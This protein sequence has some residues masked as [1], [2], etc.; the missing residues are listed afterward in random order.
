MLANSWHVRVAAFLLALVLQGAT[1]SAASLEVGPRY[2][3]LSAIATMLMLGCDTMAH[4][5]PGQWKLGGVPVPVTFSMEEHWAMSA[6]LSHQALTARP[7]EPGLQATLDA[8]MQHQHLLISLRRAVTCEIQAL[9]LEWEPA[10]SEWLAN[11]HPQVRAVYT[12]KG[13]KV[14]TQV[15]LLLHLLDRCGYPGIFDLERELK[16]GFPMTGPLSSGVGWLPRTD[17]TYAHPL[18]MDKFAEL[19]TDHLRHRLRRNTPSAHWREMLLELLE[20]KAKGRLSGPYSAPETWGVQC[21]GV[22]G[23]QIEPLPTERAFAA[24]CFAVVQSDKVRRC[25]DYRRSFH[26]ATVY[27]Q[28]TP[29]HH[30]LGTHVDLIHHYHQRGVC[31]PMIWGQDLDAAYRQVPVSPDDTAY[32]VL[33][34]PQGHTLWRHAAAPFGATASVWAFNRFAD[35]LVALARRLL[36]VPICHFVDDFTSIDPPALADSSCDSFKQ[37]FGQMGLSMKPSKEQRPACH[38]K[39]LGV[40]ITIEPDEVVLAPCPNRREKVI[41]MLQSALTSN[42]MTAAMAQQCAGKL[43]F[44]ATTFF[45][46]VGKAALQP[47]Y[48]R[49]HGLGEAHHDRLTTGLRQSIQVLLHVLQH[50]PPRILPL[51]RRPMDKIAVIYTDA[52]FQPGESGQTKVVGTKAK[53]G[54]GFVIRTP[55]GTRYDHGTVPLDFVKLFTTRRAYIFMLEILAALIGVCTVCTELPRFLI[56]FI[57][58]MAGK[59][60]LAKG[61]GKC[62]AVNMLVTAFWLLM[63]DRKWCPQFVYVKSGLNISDPISRGDLSLAIRHGWTRKHAPLL[64]LLPLLQRSLT[65][66]QGDFIWLQ[67][68]LRQEFPS[69]TEQVGE[70]DV[71]A[72]LKESKIEINE[73]NTML[74]RPGN[75]ALILALRPSVFPTFS[76]AGQGQS[77]YVAM[78]KASKTM[79]VAAA[80][81]AAT[82]AA[83]P[84]FLSG[85]AAP[86][87]VA[88]QHSRAAASS[89]PSMGALNLSSLA[90]AGVAT[91]ALVVN[92]SKSKVQFLG[93]EVTLLV[94]D[95]KSMIYIQLNNGSFNPFAVEPQRIFHGHESWL[96]VLGGAQ[97]IAFAGLIETTGFFQAASTTDGRG[98]R[99]GQFSM[100][101]STETGEPGNYG[102]GFPTFLG[103]D[104]LTGSAWGDWSLYTAS[105][106][107]AGRESKVARNFFGGETSYSS[108]DPAKELGVQEPIGI[109]DKSLTATFRVR[110]DI[111]T[112]VLQ[113]SGQCGVFMKLHDNES[114][115]PE[116]DMQ[117]LP[118]G[119]TLE[120][121]RTLFNTLFKNLCSASL[122]RTLQENIGLLC[123]SLLTKT[124]KSMQIPITS[125]VLRTWEDG[126]FTEFQHIVVQ[127]G[128]IRFSSKNNGKCTSSYITMSD[129]VFS[130][131]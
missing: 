121:L 91:S 58:N 94:R 53:N 51:T 6:T 47:M 34:T 59:F 119:T 30:D 88:P 111:L 118:E 32:T 61:Y 7:L 35:A 46:N 129:T 62:P 76:R 125:K 120:N 10:T 36:M 87:R 67:S 109:N 66:H 24:C 71:V 13:T 99:E 97:I 127:L 123:D 16:F 28:D 113:A 126:N 117:W 2:L 56:F 27:T 103:K 38:Q 115:L 83:A 79:A 78:S 4:P 25:E 104:G 45:G 90:V 84:T 75:A 100:K 101:D 12:A 52:F 68:M 102:V 114:T 95:G 96:P 74:R 42:Q 11:I 39:V 54:W 70:D 89:Q 9:I 128:F 22:D 20:D 3:P 124:P 64:R 82:M 49:G 107:R 14:A 65:C 33:T 93:K 26:N 92:R 60:A 48:S 130:W 41:A 15:P 29:H 98:P 73:E 21:V 72:A 31:Q 110:S 86:S 131:P 80:A 50:A 18:D 23:H 8:M 81:T 55:F 122:A 108:F 77:L 37:L 105:P 43:A 1:A 44:L 69:D 116:L 5:G 106:L 17:E 40:Y 112:T 63:E 57:D 19:N 85:A